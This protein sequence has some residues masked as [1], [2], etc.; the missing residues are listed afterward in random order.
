MSAPQQ[1]P[2]AI[3]RD[4]EAT[5]REVG[6]SLLWITI[7]GM[8]ASV[9]ASAYFGWE[10]SGHKSLIAAKA[11]LVAVAVDLLIIR[12]LRVA[13]R[14]RKLGTR[15]ARGKRLDN[16][17]VAMT[18]YLNALGGAAAI[19]PAGTPWAWGAMA[20][21][22]T[23]IP[24]VM[25][26]SNDTL[27]EAQLLLQEKAAAALAEQDRQ[28][29][30]A[31]AEQD[32]VTARARRERDAVV[33]AQTEKATAEAKARTDQI[34]ADR[35]KT[36]LAAEVR[37]REIAAA[38]HSLR[39]CLSFLLLAGARLENKQAID[40][41]AERR[42]RDRQRRQR[43]RQPASGTVASASPARRQ[44]SPPA[45]RQRRSPATA[46]A[47]P[48]NKL[49]VDELV[50]LA[51]AS[52]ETL[53]TALAMGRPALADWLAAEAGGG[54]VTEHKTR[55]VMARIQPGTNVVGLSRVAGGHR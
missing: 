26:M 18:Y 10:L 31:A 4:A 47:G 27:P 50:A 46:S 40:A 14:L 49:S 11:V 21:T 51:T 24:T 38:S 53:A 43:D 6:N 16:V 41:A 48:A 52:D 32:A 30:A 44:P 9:G 54:R 8:V 12:W 1:D 39:A 5:A 36:R 20:I 42:A 3:V 19:I 23:F 29:R 33:T 25:K 22:W 15:T 7:I 35:E 2:A 28:R 34:E 17:S 55:E 37:G 13:A 45:N